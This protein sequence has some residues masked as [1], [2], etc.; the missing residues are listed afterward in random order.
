MRCFTSILVVAGGVLGVSVHRTPGCLTFDEWVAAAEPPQSSQDRAPAGGE[1]P[2]AATPP[3]GKAD[4]KAAKHKHTNRLAKETSP[5]LLLHA[6]NPVDWYPWGAEALEKAKKDGR[7]I[8]L[9]IGYS[10]C[11]WCHVMERESFMDEEIAKLMNEHFVCIKVDREERPDIDEIYMTALREYG[12][13]TGSGERGGW[14][15]SMF[16]TPEAR[17]VAGFTYLPPRA[18]KKRGFKGGFLD[19]LTLLHKTWTEEPKRVNTTAEAITEA[20]QRQLRQRP[21]LT[22]KPDGEDIRKLQLALAEDF[23]AKHGGF[24]F[25]E[26]ND[27]QPKFPEP[28]NLMFLLGRARK[29]EAEA[30]RAAARRMLVKTLDSMAAGGI[31]DHLGGGFH[32]YST[33]RFWRIPHFEKMLYDNGQL[34]TVYAEAYA[35]TG[36]AQYQVVTERLLE[37]VLRELTGPHGAF[38]AA[39]DAETE[40]DEGAFYVWKT[41]ELRA[42]LG[43]ADFA[44]FAEAYGVG[45]PPNFEGRHTLLLPRP[46]AETAARRKLSAEELLA[47]LAP[48]RQKLLDLRSKRPRPLTDTKV[49]TSWNGLMIRGLADAG[50]ILKNERYLAAASKAADFILV[51]LR[52]KDGRLL[53]TYAGEQAK[54]NAYLDDYSF[55]VD[56]LIA[57]HRATGEKR[58][59]DAASEL[60]DKMIELHGDARD[61]GF[62]FTSGD[63]ESLIARSKGPTDGALP[64]GN[65]V[66]A[67]NLVYLGAALKAPKRFEQAEKT[68]AARGA[69][70]KN[71]PLAYPRMFAALAA[72]EEARKK[73]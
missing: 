1:K 68:I 20:V 11:Y 59:L 18:D 29:A 72:L 26:E 66:A 28:S 49:I 38:Y 41:Q 53:R 22:E 30:D 36:T 24:G 2:K 9:S 14:P 63:H 19:A 55:L 67:D 44:L 37:F 50:R 43:E 70:L 6:H 57:L 71:F 10:S 52:T 35:L 12:R 46:L 54:L 3:A 34:A 15:L 62:Y 58:W 48:L 13:L 5:Y 17:P 42:A 16:L 7:L 64:S 51:K 31:W 4:A 32:R 21:L 23:D 25:H 47:R 69:M 65:S 40:A 39:L 27:R 60:T 61:G 56:G 45:E 73:R 33:D 8:F